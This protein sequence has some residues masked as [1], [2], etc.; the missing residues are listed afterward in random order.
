[1]SLSMA[2]MVDLCVSTMIESLRMPSSAAPAFPNTAKTIVVIPTYNE[3]ENL[4]ALIAELHA[5]A[6]PAYRCLS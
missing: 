4:P 1:M 6:C 2:T 3:A 5:L